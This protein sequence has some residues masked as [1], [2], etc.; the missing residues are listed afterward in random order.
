MG[1]AEAPACSSTFLRSSLQAGAAT[2]AGA[3]FGTYTV[4]AVAVAAVSQGSRQQTVRLP[5]CHADHLEVS[6]AGLDRSAESQRVLS[7]PLWRPVALCDLN[8]EELVVGNEGGQPGEALP[9]TA[10][11]TNLSGNKTFSQGCSKQNML[12]SLHVQVS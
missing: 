9:A 8:A 10:A 1:A 7:P 6:A 12:P 11:N 3:G 5:T 2:A 4:Q